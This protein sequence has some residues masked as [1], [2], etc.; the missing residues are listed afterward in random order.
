MCA[1][2]GLVGGGTG[3]AAQCAG[4]TYMTAGMALFYL[5]LALGT[6]AWILS[7]VGAVRLRNVAYQGTLPASACCGNFPAAQATAAT[8]TLLAFAG[9]ILAW[10]ATTLSWRS[11]PPRR[12]RRSRWGLRRA[13]L[14]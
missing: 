5:A 6:P 2:S 9:L 7:W 8:A 3:A 14:Q 13:A 10:V 4:G 12:W 1:V 11:F